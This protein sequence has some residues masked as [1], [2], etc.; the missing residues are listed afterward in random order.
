MICMD[1]LI[2]IVM[3]LPKSSLWITMPARRR[4]AAGDDGQAR[5][6]PVVPPS[7]FLHRA[8]CQPFYHL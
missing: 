4:R 5:T 2:M 6:L 8:L 1:W 3:S 7:L